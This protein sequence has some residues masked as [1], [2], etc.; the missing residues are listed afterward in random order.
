MQFVNSVSSNGNHG[1]AY[2]VSSA[3]FSIDVAEAHQINTAV[4]FV[5]AT[6]NGSFVALTFT[7]DGSP[8]SATA[9]FQGGTQVG[10]VLDGVP[11]SSTVHVTGP[12]GFDVLNVGN[13]NN[14]QFDDTA[15]GGHQT[16]AD[17]NPFK[18][19]E[20]ESTIAT[21]TV[22]TE[23]FNVSEDE[24]AGVNT[25][26]DPNA[27]NDVNPLVDV[28]PAAITEAGAIGYAKSPTSVLAPGSL[29]AGS[30]GADEPGSYS[31]AITDGHGNP[32]S[33]VNSGL[34]TLDGTHIM[35]STD[36]NGA[37]V[38]TAGLTE[39]FKVYVDGNGFVWIAQY[40]AIAHDVDGSSQAAFDDI[41]T[42]TADLHIEATLT[43]FDGDSTSA[44]SGVALKIQFQDDGPVAVNDVDSVN[45]AALTATGNV[46]TGTDIAIGF[47]ANITDGIAD[48]KGTDGAKI[49]EVAGVTTDTAPD[50]SHNF[51]VTGQFGTLV[52][53]ENGGYTYTRFN[54][55]PGEGNDVFTYTLTDGDGDFSTAKLTVK[56]SNHGVTIKDIGSQDGDETVFENDLSA[57]RG[58]GESDGSSP[59]APNLTKFGTFNFSA[60][61]GVDDV[62]I[63]GTLVVHD[64]GV[65]N[66]NTPITT[67]YGVLTIT[68][69]NLGTGTVSYTYQLVD[70]TLAHG[71]GNNL[72]NSVFDNIPVQVTDVDGDAAGSSLIVKVVDDVPTAHVEPAL[73]VVETDGV[74]AGTNL[75]ANDTQGADGATVTAVDIGN[76]F[77]TIAPG[78]TILTNAFGTYA[79][80]ADGT[81][82]FDPNAN[83][84]N[85]SGIS[86]G[87]TYK[88]TDGDGDTSTATQAI[89]DQ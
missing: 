47:D 59:N 58:V 25:A 35:L 48:T 2:D 28:P 50:G 5:S 10:Y 1:S 37:V 70:N 6:H 40:Q 76:G 67:T 81:W 32:I 56:I 75:L 29:F 33:S 57:I 49:T 74:T 18:V 53:N 73:T 71:P 88:I 36:A 55:A 77:Q 13:Y 82:S 66:L 38:G 24:S 34:K 46:I 31:F 83:L 78:G 85:A 26:P 60:P 19:F 62:S 79:F 86:A 27:A 15:A 52:I 68:E 72:D 23:T 3:S 69:V 64:G 45:G 20:I 84:N 17:G 30:V 89:I 42:V 61:D 9:V 80:Q 8:V 16:F 44:V 51:Q 22:V 39:V 4:V 7:V 63:G 43:D 12:T 21:T 65:V 54:G 41:A 11:D 14:Y 87:F